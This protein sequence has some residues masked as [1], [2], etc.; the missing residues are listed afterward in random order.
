MWDYHFG[1]IMHNQRFIVY[2]RKDGAVSICAP[3]LTALR[4]MTG[5]GGRWDEILH[6]DREFL[7]RQIAAQAK[8]GVGERAARRFIRAM[9]FGGLTTA[10]AYDVMRDRFCSH[11][12]TGCELWTR[13]EISDRWFR[14]AWRRSPNGGPIRID[15][16]IARKLQLRHIR[17]LSESHKL[18]L[19]MDRW[20]RRVRA[21]RDLEHLRSILPDIGGKR[22]NL[23]Y[24]VVHHGRRPSLQAIGALP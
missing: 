3:S 4:Y 14:N 7:D 19:L 24:H 13:D 5:G 17:M 22:E 9:Q 23:D 15:M 2:T 21:A 18:E 12:G 11:R 10:E 16:R 6:T 1:A 20:L 8:D